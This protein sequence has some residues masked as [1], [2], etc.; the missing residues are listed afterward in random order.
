MQEVFKNF[1]CEGFIL[2]SDLD[3]LA[4][5]AHSMIYDSMTKEKAAVEIFR[6]IADKTERAPVIADELSGLCAQM[7]KEREKVS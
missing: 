5:I 6:F 3:R 1:V 2:F 4:E 7:K